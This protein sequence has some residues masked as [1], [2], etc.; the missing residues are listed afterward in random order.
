MA[1]YRSTLFQAPGRDTCDLEAPVEGFVEGAGFVG[2]AAARTA[3]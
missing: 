2:L 3:A 1:R